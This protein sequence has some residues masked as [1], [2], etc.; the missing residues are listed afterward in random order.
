MSMFDDTGGTRAWT[1]QV[2][3]YMPRGEAVCR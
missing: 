2:P 3:W 1:R